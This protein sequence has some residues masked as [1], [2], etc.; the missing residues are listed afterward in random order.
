[1][2]SIGTFVITVD[3][4]FLQIVVKVIILTMKML[5]ISIIVN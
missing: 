5:F 3:L 4:Y 2:V 1:M